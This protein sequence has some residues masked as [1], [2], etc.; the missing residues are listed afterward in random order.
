[1]KYIIGFVSTGVLPFIILYIIAPRGFLDFINHHAS[2]YCENCLYLPIINDI[3]SPLHRILYFSIAGFLVLVL[4][5][6]LLKGGNSV[7]LMDGYYGLIELEDETIK[8]TRVMNL[9]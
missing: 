7:L 3:W 9:D 8:F 2:W 5:R 6:M 1:M 4:T